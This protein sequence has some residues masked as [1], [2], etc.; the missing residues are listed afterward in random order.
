MHTLNIIGGGRVGQSL[1]KLWL[2]AASVKIGA[3]MNLTTVSAD[4]AINHLGSGTAVSRIESMPAADL[5]MITTNDASIK[6]TAEKLATSGLLDE[7]SIVFHCSGLLSSSELEAITATGVSVA[8][9]HPVMSFAYPLTN[10]HSFAGTQC[11]I[12]GDRV[13]LETLVPLFESIGAK[14]F[15]IQPDKKALYHAASVLCCNKLTALAEA[16]IQLFE[17]SGLERQVAIQMMQPLMETTL[18]NIF[19]QGTVKALTG[20]IA[21]GD[22]SSVESH[23]DALTANHD[24]ALDIYKS[25]GKIA[26]ELSEKQGSASS[27]ELQN[28]TKLLE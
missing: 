10:L 21:R 2:D 24:A 22:S 15:S 26:V 27:D 9:V 8:S 6:A 28:I 17:A 5:W 7:K 4:K 16:S 3:V 11:G 13:S 14:C 20:P 25:L 19:Q 1:V 12:E 23:I 18:S